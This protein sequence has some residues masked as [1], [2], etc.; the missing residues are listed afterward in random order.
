MIRERD[1]RDYLQDILSYAEIGVKITDGVTFEAFCINE[2]KILAAI[3]VLEVIEEASKKLPGSL[4]NRHPE[5]PWK[6]MA[7]TRDKLI[8]AY[9]LMDEEIVWRTLKEDLPTL[10]RSIKRIL[11]D[12]QEYS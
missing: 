10:K 11:E 12:V 5:V 2:E 9:H 6:D 4:K 3:Q 1:I 7:A 8:H